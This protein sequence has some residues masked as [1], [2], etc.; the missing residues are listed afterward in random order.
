MGDASSPTRFANAC[1][2]WV[3]RPSCSVKVVLAP[4]FA[5]TVPRLRELLRLWPTADALR[6]RLLEMPLVSPGPRVVAMGLVG[7]GASRCLSCERCKACVLSA[8]PHADTECF[9]LSGFGRA[10]GG[11]QATSC[12]L[13]LGK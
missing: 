1:V 5:G 2:A 8:S 9:F 7:K 4:Q 10:G 11:D 13:L 3:L 6:L 12:T